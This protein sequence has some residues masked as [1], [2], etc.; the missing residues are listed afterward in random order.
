LSR[1]LW[2]T[3]ST[4]AIFEKENQWETSEIPGWF[5]LGD[6]VLILKNFLLLWERTRF[7]KYKMFSK[8]TLHKILLFLQ[9]ILSST[10]SM[11]YI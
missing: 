7:K 1:E 11:H 3:G 6:F 4:L 2:W 8:T 10:Y 9:N 5:S